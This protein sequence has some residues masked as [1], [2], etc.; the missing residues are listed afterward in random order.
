KA[1]RPV[2]VRLYVFPWG[3]VYV[4][5]VRRGISPPFRA[6]SLA[7]GTYRIEVRNGTLPPLV[8]TVTL[9]AGESPVEIRYSFE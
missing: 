1:L 9:D 4:N 7:P 5:G 3:E 2:L 8:R 6:M